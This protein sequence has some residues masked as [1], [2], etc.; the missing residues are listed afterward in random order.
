M[1]KRKLLALP[2][3]A[4]LMIV[5]AACPSSTAKKLAVASQA[6]SHSLLNAQLAARQGVQTGVI[7]AV[8]EQQFESFLVRAAQ[9]GLVLDQSIRANQSASD[10]SGQV[11][12]FLDA[13]NQLN[14]QGIAGIKD[15]NL[16]L[17]IST[18]LTGAETSVAIIVATVGGKK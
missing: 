9:A 1:L 8:D 18:I 6:I 2:L 12:S 4:V 16:Q 11:N 3:I 15:K 5:S 17:T 10:V 7:A 14:T 13:F